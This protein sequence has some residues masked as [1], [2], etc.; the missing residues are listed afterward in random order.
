MQLLRWK[1]RRSG[2]GRR[3][4]GWGGWRET[5]QEQEEKEENHR[6]GLL[7]SAISQLLLVLPSRLILGFAYPFSQVVTGGGGGVLLKLLALDPNKT[8]QTDLGSVRPLFSS[9]SRQSIRKRPQS[10]LHPVPFSN[11][12]R[13]TLFSREV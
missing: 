3:G 5:A 8:K 4:G 12:T 6:G 13:L 1:R 2:S 9:P 11:K 7:V 10:H